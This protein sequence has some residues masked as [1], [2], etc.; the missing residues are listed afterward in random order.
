MVIQRH[1]HLTL[2][3]QCTGKV[4]YSHHYT[5]PAR[6]ICYRSIR[7]SLHRNDNCLLETVSVHAR[8]VRWLRSGNPIRGGTPTDSD[9]TRQ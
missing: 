7:H 2:V 1:K 4:T 9:T 8:D 3:D 5:N 6:Y